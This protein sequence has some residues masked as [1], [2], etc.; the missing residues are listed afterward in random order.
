MPGYSSV[1]VIADAYL[2]FAALIRRWHGSGKDNVLDERGLSCK[3]IG[4]IPADGLVE[5]VAMGM[6]YSIADWGIAQMAKRMG[7][8]K[9]MNISASGHLTTKTI[10]TQ[11]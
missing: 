1:Q 9:T 10:L 8:R 6:E 11:Q 7:R 5:S 4:Y 2:D 3:K